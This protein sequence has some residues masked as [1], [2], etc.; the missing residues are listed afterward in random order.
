MAWA[1]LCFV[2]TSTTCSE[3]TDVV[4]TGVSSEL[5]SEVTLTNRLLR[6]LRENPAPELSLSSEELEVGEGQGH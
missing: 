1:P 4:D 2:E 3:E 6:T 5:S